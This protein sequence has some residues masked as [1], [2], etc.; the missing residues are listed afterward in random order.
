MAT[1]LDQL[2]DGTHTGGRIR[3]WTF[4]SP[5][6]RAWAERALRLDGA[7]VRVRSAYKPLVF[8]FLEEILLADADAIAI[9]YPTVVGV[10]RARFRLECYPVT[11]LVAPLPVSFVAKPAISSPG[12]LTYD[13][14]LQ[15]KRE[16]AVTVAAPN[17]FVADP[18]GDR[19]LANT[20]WLQVTGP[21]AAARDEPLVTGLQQ[22]FDEAVQVLRD[23][24]SSGALQGARV[25][26]PVAAPVYDHALPV[27]HEHVSTAEVL[28]EEIYFAALEAHG[29][30]GQVVPDIVPPDTHGP[31]T[32][33]PDTHGNV[34][35]PRPHQPSAGLATAR[36]C[37]TLPAVKA[38]LD[39]LGGA[40]Y[41]AHSQ[42]GRPVWGSHI[43]GAGPG[44]VV[45]AAQHGNE[46]AGVI[47]ALRAVD[48]C[49]EAGASI[50]V[51]PVENPDG[52]ALY[53]EL[54]ARHPAHMHHAARFTASGRD[55]ED[56]GTD[57]EGRIRQLGHE[58]TG[59]ALHLNLHGYP[60]HEWTRPLSGYLPRGYE[61]WTIPKGFFLILR[62][63]PDWSPTA[64]KILDAVVADLAAFDPLVAF[65]LRQI[66][67][68]R[69]Y[70][71]EAPLEVRDHIPV[72]RADSKPG[73]RFPVT[74]ITESPDEGL[75][76]DPY[77]L[78][79]T[80]HMRAVRAAI[81]AYV[82][83]AGT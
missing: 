74:L 13:V 61:T 54:R 28:H 51:A 45:S 5:S 77:V 79:H 65:N 6:V 14:I 59:A 38:H 44:V 31:D 42:Q 58:R 2:P 22:A 36:H 12:L 19:V 21:I 30:I 17:H 10:P 25:T 60:A 56:L 64:G 72:F 8:A 50:A 41:Q 66:D 67:R 52:Y 57:H 23:A 49:R 24:A 37:L 80:A 48:H 43:A 27:A 40:P 33:G 18:T 55:L 81:A 11:D 15:G 32:H 73:A 4:D 53:E 35:A 71:P 26:V 78:M 1:W 82:S 62:A 70:L 47:G 46:T 9:H 69:Q 3:V 63:D 29:P 39:A 76:G 34:S 16:R 7:D 20:G 83:T 75:S 68:H